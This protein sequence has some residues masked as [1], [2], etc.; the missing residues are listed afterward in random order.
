MPVQPRKGHQEPFPT[1]SR[2]PKAFIS[3][4]S[5]QAHK[6]CP[7]RHWGRP[8]LCRQRRWPGS[9]LR[10]VARPGFVLRALG[11]WGVGRDVDGTRLG[12]VVEGEASWE[13][14]GFD[15]H[16][17]LSPW[18]FPNLDRRCPARNEYSL[19]QEVSCHDKAGASLNQ[20]NI[21]H[22]NRIEFRLATKSAHSFVCH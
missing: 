5:Y 15:S 11:I 12:E 14:V 8:G 7:T 3:E 19:L 17:P 6:N 20:A 18:H 2:K 10:R 22:V 4:G 21:S 16:P 1:R 9:S 13:D